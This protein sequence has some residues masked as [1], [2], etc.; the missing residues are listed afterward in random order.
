[1][2]AVSLSPVA[3]RSASA[4]PAVIVPK[5]TDVVVVHLEGEGAPIVRG[6]GSIRTVSGDSIW[7]GPATPPPNGPSGIVAR[8]DVPSA[9]LPADDYIVTLHVT[10]GNGA[11]HERARYFLRVRER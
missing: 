11:E 5:G 7:D 2:F 1:M 8:L 4:T 9:R 3:V 10:D 6:R